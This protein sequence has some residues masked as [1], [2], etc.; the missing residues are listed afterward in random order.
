MEA[1]ERRL[2]LPAGTESVDVLGCCVSIAETV[3]NLCTCHIDSAKAEQWNVGVVEG[4]V[5]T[6]TTVRTVV[7]PL[8]DGSAIEET[9]NLL[10]WSQS[11]VFATVSATD[12]HV[13]QGTLVAGLLLN[14]L[15][16]DTELIIYADNLC[17]GRVRVLVLLGLVFSEPRHILLR[18]SEEL[19]KDVH[20][21]EVT[22]P[23]VVGVLVRHTST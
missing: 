10:S 19:L 1:A 13:E 2:V 12:T 23:V 6:G 9:G 7:G 5:M 15:C 14:I 8:H 4:V 22:S 21:C 11:A 18:I 17:L 16:R 20:T 3:L